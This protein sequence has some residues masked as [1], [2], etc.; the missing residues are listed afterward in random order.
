ML[1][2]LITGTKK[3]L[4]KIEQTKI[5]Y[6]FFLVASL[7]AFNSQ[8]QGTNSND[9]TKTLPV[10]P[11]SMTVVFV[12]YEIVTKTEGN[13]INWSTIL[14]SN[15]AKYEIQRSAA[16]QTFETIGTIQSKGTTSVTVDY[17]FTDT[18]PNSGKNIYRIKMIDTRNGVQYSSIKMVTNELMTAQIRGTNAYPN[19][20][21]PGMAITL[22]VNEPGQ[23][24]IRI[25]SLSGRMI[26]AEKAI[27]AHQSSLSIRVPSNLTAG[28]YIMEVTDQ[29]T[30]VHFQQK[31]MIQ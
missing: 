24:S 22:D 14:E 3:I 11:F 20:A 4:M 31:I 10:V 25:H 8:A 19:P 30:Q 15:L 28:M 5:G 13:Q 21:R 2:M 12:E 6:L 7:F 29:E 26:F 16:N 1:K 17:S 23:Y 9:S 27:A 18:R